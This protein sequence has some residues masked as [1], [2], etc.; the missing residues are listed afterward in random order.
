MYSLFS[1]ETTA[2]VVGV[3]KDFE[4]KFGEISRV[5]IVTM[6]YFAAWMKAERDVISRVNVPLCHFHFKQIFMRKVRLL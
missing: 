1:K 3:F 4:S 5:E 2:D 6:D